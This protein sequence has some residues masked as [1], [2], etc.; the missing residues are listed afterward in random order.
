MLVIFAILCCLRR[1]LSLL[2][3]KAFAIIISCFSNV[4]KS[5]SLMELLIGYLKTFPLEIGVGGQK[6]EST[7]TMGGGVEAC[8]SVLKMGEWSNSCHFGAHVLTE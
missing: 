1:R 8:V 3:Y 5:I 7:Y 6:G 2:L 4:L